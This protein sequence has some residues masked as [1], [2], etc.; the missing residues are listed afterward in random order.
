[1]TAILYF[2]LMIINL[3]YNKELNK[4]W[5]KTFKLFTN[6]VMFRKCLILNNNVKKCLP[7]Q[8]K[9]CGMAHRVRLY[10]QLKFKPLFKF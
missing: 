7:V 1:M 9:I 5:K 3:L 6:S 2:L 8:E 4:L 10:R